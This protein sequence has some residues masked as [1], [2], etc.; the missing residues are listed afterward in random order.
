MFSSAKRWAKR[1]QV[2]LVVIGETAIGLS[3]MYLIGYIVGSKQVM[4]LW[5]ASNADYELFGKFLSE[6]GLR[7]EFNQVLLKRASEE[8][9]L[10]FLLPTS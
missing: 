6:H 2:V 7:E 3:T 10:R 1:N 5:K 4:D 8:G 9:S